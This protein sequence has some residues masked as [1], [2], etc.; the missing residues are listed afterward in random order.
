MRKLIFLILIVG[1]V[2]YLRNSEYAQFLTFE[3]L[4][5]N[6]DALKAFSEENFIYTAGV[7]LISY[8]LVAGLN[9]PGAVIMSIAGGF[10]FG[11]MLGTLI[12]VSG[13]TAGASLGFLMSRY[14]FGN[15][16]NNKY[17]LQLKKFNKELS[18]NGYLYMLTLRLI[19]AF[20]FFLIN[21]MAGM[22]SLRL[23]TF[24]WTSFL[25]MIPGGFVFVYAGSRLNEV[26]SPSDIFSG[27]ILSAFVL[28]GLLMLIPVVY[29]KLKSK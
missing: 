8:I 24:V 26:N 3:N 2:V 5:S 20:P 27:G 12:A 11:S 25:G 6:A 19:P 13:A 28:F 14:I 23:S 18:D 21:I 1:L 9:I 16:L 29:K 7:Y 22:T 4:K 17:E 10:I 15:A